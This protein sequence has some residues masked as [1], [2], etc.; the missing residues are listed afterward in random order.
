MRSPGI[1][2]AQLFDCAFQEPIVSGQRDIAATT[3]LVDP[4]DDVFGQADRHWH[5]TGAERRFVEPLLL[6]RFVMTS[7]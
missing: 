5:R 4:L 3:L 1:A 2:A 6:L 7:W